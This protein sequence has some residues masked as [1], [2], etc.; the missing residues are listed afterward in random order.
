MVTSVRRDRCPNG[1][2]SEGQGQGGQRKASINPAAAASAVRGLLAEQCKSRKAF[3][4]TGRSGGPFHLGLDCPVGQ[5]SV[6]CAGVVARVS[7][8]ICG[9]NCPD[10]ASLIRATNSC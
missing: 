5:S 8:A 7:E 10:V 4:T 6:S 3:G 9:E 1:G 2:G